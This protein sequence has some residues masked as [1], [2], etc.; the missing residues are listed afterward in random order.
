MLVNSARNMVRDWAEDSVQETY[1]RALQYWNS[2]DFNRPFDA[3][4]SNIFKNSTLNMYSVNKGWESVEDESFPPL[5]KPLSNPFISCHLKEVLARIA[6]EPAD[7]AFIY[8][9][10]LIQQFKSCEIARIVPEKTSSIDKMVSRFRE[11]LVKEMQ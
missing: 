2:Y 5:N 4:M 1:S 8:R 11:K 9:L 3:W 7:K 6:E 10:A